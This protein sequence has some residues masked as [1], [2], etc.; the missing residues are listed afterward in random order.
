MATINQTVFNITITIIVFLPPRPSSVARS[1]LRLNS[2]QAAAASP[3]M[4]VVIASTGRV[5]S[6]RLPEI[7]ADRSTP[8]T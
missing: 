3:N 6:R 5:A 2:T 4:A 1:P 7:Y 8:T